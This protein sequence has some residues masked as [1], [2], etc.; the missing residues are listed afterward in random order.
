MSVK[1]WIEE[2]GSIVLPKVLRITVDGRDISRTHLSSHDV[3]LLETWLEHAEAPRPRGLGDVTEFECGGCSNCLLEYDIDGVGW[4]CEHPDTD[5][6][7][8]EVHRA[9]N[10]DCF[11]A[12]CPLLRQPVLLVPKRAP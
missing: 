11:P 9:W 10:D 6:T 7:E 1:V 2:T 8:E 4:A 12:R 3:P 5:V